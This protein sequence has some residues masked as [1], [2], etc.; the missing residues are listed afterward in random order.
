MKLGPN[1]RIY[2]AGI[3]SHDYLSVIEHPNCPGINCM[4]KPNS[5]ALPF[6]NYSGISNLPHFN[7]I[8]S[9]YDCSVVNSQEQTK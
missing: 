7:I 3:G 6:N 8:P 9:S 1:G 2:I 4:V 5:I